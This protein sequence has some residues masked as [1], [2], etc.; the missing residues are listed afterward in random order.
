MNGSVKAGDTHLLGPDSFGHFIP[1]VIKSIQ[2]K[3]VT[4]ASAHAGQSASF[5][6]KKIKRS[7]IRKGMVMAGKDANPRASWE[8]EAEILVLFHSS[9]SLLAMVRGWSTVRR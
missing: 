7:F 8:F 4:S 6:L 2:R 5:A 3:R 1:C 9:V